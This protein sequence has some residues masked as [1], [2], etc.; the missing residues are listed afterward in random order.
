MKSKKEQLS[1]SSLP[2]PDKEGGRVLQQYFVPGDKARSKSRASSHAMEFL[3]RVF[4][5]EGAS[6]FFK[7]FLLRFLFDGGSKSSDD[8]SGTLSF[9]AL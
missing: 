1:A 8:C 9:S 4:T 2:V 7:T 6:R 3:S 5:S